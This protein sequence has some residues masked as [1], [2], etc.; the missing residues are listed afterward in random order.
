MS[1]KPNII[2]DT[3]IG[4]DPDDLFALLLLHKLAGERIKLIVTANEVHTKRLQFLGQIMYKLNNWADTV[5]GSGLGLEKFTVEDLLDE[6]ASSTANLKR[7]DF[8]SQMQAVVRTSENVTYI[9]IGGFTNLA[10][11]VDSFPEEAK[12][13]KIFLMGGAI[14]YERYPNWIEYNIKIDPISAEKVINSGLKITLIMAQTT[15]NPLY[16]VTK[17]SSIYKK[18]K[19]SN[20]PVNQLLVK[21]CDLWFKQKG[22]GTSMHDPLTVAVALGYNFVDFGTSRVSLKDGKFIRHSFF[23]KEGNLMKLSEPISKGKEFMNFLETTLLS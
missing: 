21:H 20:S 18:L 2:L 17:E 1:I 8:L 9:G 15:H 5:R 13:M 11:F 10:K 4:Y 16:E 22:H 3:D 23:G 7:V 19:Q 14:D 12:K 6:K